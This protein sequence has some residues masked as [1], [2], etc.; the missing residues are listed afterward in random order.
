[1]N[2]K[3]IL[4]IQVSDNE[5]DFSAAS[6]CMCTS[7]DFKS[8]YKIFVNIHGMQMLLCSNKGSLSLGSGSSHSIVNL[9]NSCTSSLPSSMDDK[10]TMNPKGSN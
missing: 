8:L 5:T 10:K 4:C 2:S 9:Q 1:M 6:V 3:Y 7:Q